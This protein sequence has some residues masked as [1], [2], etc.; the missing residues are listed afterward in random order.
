MTDYL[1]HYRRL[2][3]GTEAFMTPNGDVVYR[4][5][6]F[7]GYNFYEKLLKPI[8]QH[9]NSN[10]LDSFSILDYGCGKAKHI[11]EPRCDGKTFHQ[12]FEGRCQNYY[13]YDPGY[14]RYLREPPLGSHFD[15]IACADVMEH[16]PEADV[17]AALQ[18]MRDYT[19]V[20][21]KAFFSISG[22]EAWKKFIHG[23]NLHV[24]VKPL[25]WWM[26]QL[27]EHYGHAFHL[28]YTA[29]RKTV[30]VTSDANI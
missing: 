25:A 5:N 23:E 6:L 18:K 20:G 4:D 28:V 16:I 30:Q 29:N 10:K 9:V 12:Y 22:D 2:H 7:D 3:D 27:R 21:G 26:E 8:A 11:Y 19:Y 1:E 24:T 14:N 15:I 17:P 13:C